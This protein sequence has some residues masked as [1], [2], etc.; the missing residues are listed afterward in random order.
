MRSSRGEVY[1]NRLSAVPK[2]GPRSQLVPRTGVVV[3]GLN[4]VYSVGFDTLVRTVVST[5][6]WVTAPPLENTVAPQ[7]HSWN[8]LNRLMTASCVVISTLRVPGIL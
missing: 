6:V 4:A 8:W 2:I 1:A 7:P 3:N 5:R